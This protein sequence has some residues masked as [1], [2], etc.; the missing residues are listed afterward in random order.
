M[1]LHTLLLGGDQLV[2]SGS[3]IM[4]KLQSLCYD[5]ERRGFTFDKYCSL[6]VQGHVDHDDLQQYGVM[7]LP[8]ALKILW[9]QNGIKDTTLDAVRASINASPGN[10]TTYTAVQDAYVNF[11]L[12][13]KQNDPPRAR[14]V[15][16]VRGRRR[17]DGPRSERGGHGRGR[18]D[19]RKGI[20]SEEELASCKVELR[21][22][23]DEE[24]K[25][26]T[27]LEKQ[28]LHKLRYP[29]RELGTGP[30]RHRDRSRRGDRAT[31]AETSA[32][33]TKRAKD[34]STEEGDHD[35]QDIQYGRNR[36]NPAVE[37]RQ[38]TKSQKIDKKK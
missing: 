37:G 16:S 5:G 10:F 29:D 38:I 12:Q 8:E 32:S 25:R 13:Q 18:G 23:S 24:Y 3:A 28:K 14:Q 17:S 7:P 9:F 33:G 30:T 34:P 19:R 11:R 22:Y 2:A 4:T 21:E 27:P 36:N 31:I 15:A 35:G 6:H 20:F 1:T 26:L